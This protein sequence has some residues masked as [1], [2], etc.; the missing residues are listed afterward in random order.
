MA[1]LIAAS[2]LCGCRAPQKKQEKQLDP[3]F[4]GFYCSGCKQG[5]VLER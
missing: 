3:D 2:C 4:K 5:I 1:V